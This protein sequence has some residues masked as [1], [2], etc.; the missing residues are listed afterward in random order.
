MW[1]VFKWSLY[2]WHRYYEPR[3]GRYITSDPIGLA[4]GLNTYGY[5][6]GNPVIGIDPAG[7][8]AG[9]NTKNKD[10]FRG[11]ADLLD[12][13]LCN[14]WPASCLLK[15]VRWRCSTKDECGRIKFFYIGSGEPYVARPGYDP[16]DDDNCV[17]VDNIINPDWWLACLVIIH[18]WDELKWKNI[19]L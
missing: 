14:W 15:C 1:I 9:I 6:G 16:N 4:G 19:L 17:C 18:L 13:S 12:T 10:R 5:V 2:N 7:L 8:A 3:A 11:A